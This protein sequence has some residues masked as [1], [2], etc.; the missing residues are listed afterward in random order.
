MRAALLFLLALPLAAQMTVVG[1]GSGG[2]GGGATS[3]TELS[4]VSAKRGNAS[5]VQMAT[6][7]TAT[8]DCA[9]FDANGNLIS[10]G[11][12]C[13]SGGGA[14]TAASYWLGSADAT[15]S[16][17]IVVNDLA[18]LETAIAGYDFS[19]A[20]NLTGNIAAARMSTNLGAALVTSAGAATSGNFLRGNGSAFVSALAAYSDID[21]TVP[22]A[23]V[24]ESNVTQH[25]A[26]L[27][28]TKSQ[29]SDLDN[30]I[31]LLTFQYVSTYQPQY[32]FVKIPVTATIDGSPTC[33]SDT[34]TFTATIYQSDTPF[35]NTNPVTLVTMSCTTTEGGTAPTQASIAAG[36]YLRVVYSSPS[37]DLEGSV[38][39]RF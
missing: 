31:G 2:E 8:D 6:G 26:A 25:Q 7:A 38:F 12:E 11:A 1:E 37:T 15:L 5:I 32:Q 3:L 33:V 9:K 21:G 17:E 24:A 22:D 10:A 20:A 23:D 18:T 13:G 34:G 14:P 35:A 36:K 29:I 30:A 28:L 16:A 39:V 4:D 19:D 27:S